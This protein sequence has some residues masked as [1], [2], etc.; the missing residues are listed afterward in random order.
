MKVGVTRGNGQ[1]IDLETGE[2]GLHST[3][4]VTGNI[5]LVGSSFREGL[6]VRSRDNTK[7]LV[8]AFDARTGKQLWRFNTMPGVG[9]FGHDTWENDS[10]YTTGNTGVWT[11]ITVDEEAGIAYLPVEMPTGSRWHRPGTICLPRRW[12]PWT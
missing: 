11:Q 9:E 7:G 6:A 4:T 12:W 3:P 1:Q 5:I 2:I 10:W 8:R